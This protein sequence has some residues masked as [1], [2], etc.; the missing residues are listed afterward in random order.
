MR[1]RIM[2]TP[3]GVNRPRRWFRIKEVGPNYKRPWY[4]GLGG[5][6]A[7]VYA[8]EVLVKRTLFFDH[9]ELIRI[10]DDPYCTVNGLYLTIEFAESKVEEL[11]EEPKYSFDGVYAN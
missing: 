5:Y 8:I 10:Y 2:C 7:P 6:V 4:F 9:W 11:L 1:N 3:P